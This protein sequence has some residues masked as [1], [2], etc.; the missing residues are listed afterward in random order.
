MNSLEVFKAM[1]RKNANLEDTA[2]SIP[3]GMCIS[4]RQPALPKCYSDAG[5]RE[6]AISGMCE[7]CFDECTKEDDTEDLGPPTGKCANCSGPIFGGR[8]TVC[9]DNCHEEYAAYLNSMR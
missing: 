3:A 2:T 7:Q 5:R 4:C 1:L 6:Y 8:S 9:S